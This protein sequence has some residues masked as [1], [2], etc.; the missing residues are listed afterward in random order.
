[1]CV[2]TG[3]S[4]DRTP[5]GSS[6]WAEGP[7]RRCSSTRA[8]AAASTLPGIWPG[9]PGSSRPTPEPVLGPAE[10][11][12][13]GPGSATSMMASASPGRLRKPRA[14]A[15]G[16]AISSN[17]PISGRRRWRARRSGASTRSSPSSARSTVCR[18]ATVWRCDSMRAGQLSPAW[19]NGCEQNVPGCRATP[20][21][22]GQSI[23]C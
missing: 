4:P 1:M 21:P 10:G 15:M 16:G 6:P 2:T 22:P 20:K 8:I 23:T 18:P 5:D 7:R 13:R 12:T 9:M 11:R 3:H 17:W 19:K 14:G